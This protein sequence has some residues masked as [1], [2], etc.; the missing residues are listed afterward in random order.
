MKIPNPFNSWDEYF[1]ARNAFYHSDEWRELR[2]QVIERSD[3]KCVYCGRRPTTSNPINIDHR[4]PLCR[5]WDLRNCLANLQL[6][7]SECNKIKGGKSHAKMKKLFEPKD[8]K[9]KLSKKERR[10]LREERRKKREE[11]QRAEQKRKNDAFF[12][13]YLK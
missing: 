6:T 10:R 7:C 5:R 1:E 13:N 9:K 12:A 2:K 4:I 8:I 3:G 11:K